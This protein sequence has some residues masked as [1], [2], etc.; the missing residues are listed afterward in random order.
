MLTRG[1]APTKRTVRRGPSGCTLV[2]VRCHKLMQ[3]YSVRHVRKAQQEGQVGGAGRHRPKI[4]PEVRS[5][6]RLV[7]R[8]V[9]LGRTR[10]GEAGTDGA[11]IYGRAM[12]CGAWH[13]SARGVTRRA[14]PSGRTSA[15]AGEKPHNG[16]GARS[17]RAAPGTETRRFSWLQQALVT[18]ASRTARQQKRVSLGT[19]TVSKKKKKKKKRERWREIERKPMRPDTPRNPPGRR[20]VSIGRALACPA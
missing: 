6:G 9:G 14:Q 15:A 16:P 20:A 11:T 8:L 17:W 7:G 4:Q 1:S 19:A 5:V 12:E 18:G 10:E 2:A 3:R 13:R